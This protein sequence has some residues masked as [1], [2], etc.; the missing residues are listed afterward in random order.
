FAF[1]FIARVICSHHSTIYCQRLWYNDPMTGVSRQPAD[2]TEK[3]I[4]DR[5]VLQKELGRG[6]SGIVYLAQDRR[7]LDRPVVVKLLLEKYYQDEWIKTKFRQEMEALSRIDH[8]GV[9][10][11]LDAGD[12]PDGTPYLVMQYVAGRSLRVLLESP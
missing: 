7:V 11:L 1:L 4:G 2:P 8:P 3:V 10:G 5:Y 12:L 6:G 9:V